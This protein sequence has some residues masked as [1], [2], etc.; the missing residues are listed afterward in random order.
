MLP[1]RAKDA[2]I[3]EGEVVAVVEVE[4]QP[5]M[6]G[7]VI[8]AFEIDEAPS[9]PEVQREPHP[10]FQG[11]EQMLAVTARPLHHTTS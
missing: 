7:V 5:I 1:I 11:R 3:D 2:L 9:H 6:L 4:A 10:V 8:E